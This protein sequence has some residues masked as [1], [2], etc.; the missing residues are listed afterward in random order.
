MLPLGIVAKPKPS[1]SFLLRVHR[2]CSRHL[3]RG[4]NSLEYMLGRLPAD[5]PAAI[6]VVQHMPAAF[7]GTFA[8][9]A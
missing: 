5:F 3:H 1:H 9:Q 8:S 6:L 7:T 4:P 2:S